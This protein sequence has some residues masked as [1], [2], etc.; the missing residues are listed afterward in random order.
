VAQQ[1]QSNIQRLQD[2]GFAI[3]VPL[4]E[5]YAE[6]LEGLKPEEMDLLTGTSELLVRVQRDLE[7]AGL[8]ETDDYTA[9]IL[10]PPF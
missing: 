2:A 3:K 10:M 4:P 8:S 5:H 1:G 6:V 7:Q 9:Y